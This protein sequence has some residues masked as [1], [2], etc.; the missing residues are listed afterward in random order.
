MELAGSFLHYKDQTSDYYAGSA[1]IAVR[2]YL[3]AAVGFYGT[4]IHTACQG[5]QDKGDGKKGSFTSVFV[6]AKLDRLLIDLE[7]G[8]ISGVTAGFGYNSGLRNPTVDQ[9][10]SSLS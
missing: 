3:F 2:M 6:F 1:I 4:T 9:V 5:R 7:F 10:T 8:E